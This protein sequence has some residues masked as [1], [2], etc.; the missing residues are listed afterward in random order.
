M[1]RKCLKGL[2]IMAGSLDHD[3]DNRCS[4]G[5]GTFYNDRTL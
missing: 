5:I 4:S 1:K 2:L 3:D